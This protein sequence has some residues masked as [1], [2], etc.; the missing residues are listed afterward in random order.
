MSVEGGHEH[1]RG[2]RI[3]ADHLQNVEA[4]EL[5]HLDVE[6]EHVGSVGVDRAEGG[7][8]IGALGDDVHVGHRV[9]Q[10]AEPTSGRGLV[11]H[12]HGLPDAHVD[13]PAVSAGISSRT[14]VPPSGR[15][16]TSNR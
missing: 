16:V 1:D 5:G 11:V 4:R 8:A 7:G 15:A 14:R 12:D 2:H 6:E 10:V 13:G 9:E 3:R